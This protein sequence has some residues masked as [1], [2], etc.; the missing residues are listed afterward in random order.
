MDIEALNIREVRE[1]AIHPGAGWK[2]VSILLPIEFEFISIV[3]N[4]GRTVH[5]DQS[6]WSDRD[7]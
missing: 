4:D 6:A 1:G 3:L 2:G 5:V 7:D